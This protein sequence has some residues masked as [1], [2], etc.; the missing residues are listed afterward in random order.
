MISQTMVRQTTTHGLALGSPYSKPSTATAEDS[1]PHLASRRRFA[2]LHSVS[3][4]AAQALCNAAIRLRIARRFT[5]CLL[6]VGRNAFERGNCAQ[7]VASVIAT[8]T[9]DRLQQQER[10][11][12]SL[13]E[14]ARAGAIGLV[15]ATSPTVEF[16]KESAPRRSGNGSHGTPAGCDHSNPG[17]NG[18]LQGKG[19]GQKS[20]HRPPHLAQ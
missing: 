14:P 7:H 16:L 17:Q 20:G 2:K 19:F 10:K 11:Q 5:P 18:K 15:R 8:L 6:T 1:L 13:K 9:A 12:M 4:A 3:I